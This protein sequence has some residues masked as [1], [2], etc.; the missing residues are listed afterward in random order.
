MAA[1][2]LSMRKIREVLRLKWGRGLSH[3]A[4]A[5]ACAV[6]VGTVSDYLSRASAAGVSWPLPEE[7]DDGALEAR[8]FSVADRSRERTLPDFA[9]IH[10]ELRRKGV[11]LS[12]LWMEYA[13]SHPDGYR[14]SQ[15][16]ELYRR[17]SRTVSVV[18]RQRHRAGEK[19]F[20]DFSGLQPTLTDP[21][22]GDER[23]VE[24]F[25]AALGASSLTYA[26][27]CERQ[28]LACWTGAHARMSEYFGGSSEIWVPDNPKCAI[29]RACR[30]DPGV[31]RSY[32]E[33][34]AHYGAVVVPARVRKPRDKAKVE[35]AVQ[36][37]QRWILARLRH[38]TFFSL[39][40][41]NV[42][43]RELLDELND[44]EMRDFGKSRRE[45]Y[46]ELDKPLLKALPASRYELAEWSRPKVSIDY[47]VRVDDAFYSV[48]YQ[49]TGKTVDA[50]TTHATVEIFHKSRR[51]TS[52]VRLFR[53][54]DWSTKPEH[55]PRSHR[56]H[57][58]WSPSRIIRWAETSGKSVGQLVKTIMEQRPHPEQGFR[59]SLG[60]IRLGK[61]YGNAR[62]E[63]ACMRALSLRSSSYRT[64][65]NILSSGTDRLP[66]PGEREQRPTLPF[67]GNVRG[68]SYYRRSDAQSADAGEDA[69]DETVGD[70]RRV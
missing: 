40:E 52:H 38:R 53:K 29:T 27:A 48:P 21:L 62:L 42:A 28:D 14:Y 10:Q 15:Y 66:L 63:A 30:Y 43:I 12:L 16:C 35:V 3:R 49:L 4:I 8:L 6:G 17:W 61:K 59:A 69:A 20:I 68:G 32:V 19:T 1:K 65:K 18:M 50:R 55:T 47:H 5:K 46:E 67:H 2:R 23:K 44:R 9:A 22:T 37:A 51:I 34:A 25:V 45:L 26:E 13:A 24:L 58:E 56:E 7:L 36:V 11:T 60:V 31:N 54:G 64:V 70:G 33:C 41:L 57:A 39:G